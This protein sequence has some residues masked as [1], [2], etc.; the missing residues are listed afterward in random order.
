MQTCC[1]IDY[2]SGNVHSARKA[3]ALAGGGAH[4]VTLSGDPDVIARA[5]R[6]VLPGVGAFASCVG[7]LRA[8]DGVVDAI[9]DFARTGRPFLGICVGMQLMA[10]RGEEHGGADGLGLIAGQ[11]R[12]L[13]TGGLP[14]PHMGWNDVTAREPR[15]P[16]LPP[17]GNA[18]FVH[19]YAYE[20]DDDAVIAATAD[21]PAPFPAMIAQGN[22]V[23]TQFHPEKSQGFG[24]ALL[25]GFLEWSP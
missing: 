2:G 15:H 25:A 19:S 7:R 4:A 6:V 5:D 3:L 8:A 18:Y 17:D 12:K 20:P 1:L 10:T 11:V 21:Y 14:S 24:L 13:D 22:L 23:G 16:V 9:A